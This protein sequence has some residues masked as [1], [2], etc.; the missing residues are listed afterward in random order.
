MNSNLNVNSAPVFGDNLNPNLASN[1]ALTSENFTSMI[2]KYKKSIGVIIVLFLIY[3]YYNQSDTTTVVAEPPKVV[4]NKIIKEKL[5]N[6]D[7][8]EKGEDMQDN[9]DTI[10]AILH[11]NNIPITD[12]ILTPRTKELITACILKTNIQ[13]NLL[14]TANNNNDKIKAKN[15][16]KEIDLQTIKFDSAVKL[17]NHSLQEQPPSDNA[18]IDAIK[19]TVKLNSVLLSEQLKDV[20]HTEQQNGNIDESVKLLKEAEKQETKALIINNIDKLDTAIQSAKDVE[21]PHNINKLDKL[22]SLEKNKVAIILNSEVANNN[23]NT[24][25]DI[26]NANKEILKSDLVLD[27]AILKNKIDNNTNLN[28]ENKN[29]LLAQIDIA[30][31]K[32]DIVIKAEVLKDKIDNIDTKDKNF[33]QLRKN[34]ENAMIKSDII[35]TAEA[36]KQSLIKTP[37]INSLDEDNGS[38]KNIQNKAALILKSEILKDKITELKKNIN[39]NN[40][41]D[42]NSVD[43]SDHRS[44]TNSSVNSP[45]NYT[46]NSIKESD[47]NTE[48]TDI[49][50]E[51]KIAKNNEK[52]I[53]KNEINKEL[54]NNAVENN[55]T[56]SIQKLKEIVKISENR[57][58]RIIILELEKERDNTKRHGCGELSL[59][60]SLIDGK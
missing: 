37:T 20:A 12:A 5:E 36:E 23:I 39:I 11:V 26:Y 18:T 28:K 32:V 27:S 22:L 9:K 45:R 3:V 44:E 55:D 4:E 6:V 13:L 19:N 7:R 51:R 16:I 60:T 17:K 34:T 38:D 8:Q 10:S 40:T 43:Y 52:I 29:L 48:L 57:V 30:D 31:K 41:E 21:T 2:E 35:L 25:E 50:K 59:A 14:S 53:I 47:K 15:A 24:K 33:P 1:L 42:S 46:K 54:L 58:S 56:S 49:L